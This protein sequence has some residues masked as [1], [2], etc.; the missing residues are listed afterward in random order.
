MISA[1]DRDCM[2]D[3][4][5]HNCPAQQMLRQIAE[6]VLAAYKSRCKAD[7]PSFLQSAPVFEGLAVFHGCQRQEGRPSEA[8]FLQ[9]I[10]HALRR[11][12]II[13]HDILDTAAKR[14]LDSQLIFFL[15]LD[16]IC[17]YAQDSGLAALLFHNP[18]D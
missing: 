18:A 2:V 12:L 8:V 14:C 11:V 6:P 5:H 4:V 1:G 7:D 17:D 3:I 15:C 10:D 13:R 9:E 16:Q